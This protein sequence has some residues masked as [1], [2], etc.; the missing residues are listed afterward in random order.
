VPEFDS[1]SYVAAAAPAVG[2]EL[3]ERETAEVAA[4]LTRI[5]AF[6]RLV[7]GLEL[8]LEDEAAPRFEP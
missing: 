8:A 6:A 2:L 5:H 4:Q 1:E 7:L 3:T